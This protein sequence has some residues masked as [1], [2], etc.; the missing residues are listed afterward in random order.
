[1]M[2]MKMYEVVAKC[3]HVGRKYYAQKNFAVFALN[4]RDA[5]KITRE[6]PRVKHHHKD[7]ILS[8]REIDEQRFYEIKE[9]TSRDPYFSC[10]CI[11]DQR[12]YV[13][14]DI[15]TEEAWMEEEFEEECCKPVFVGKNRIR[16][17]KKY[18]RNFRVDEEG[19]WG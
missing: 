12:S 14:S 16:K 13:D 6:L 7:A 18:V 1:M 15:Y 10:T 2:E 9:I 19:I 8:V 5:A 11:Q 17:P 4:G 3:G